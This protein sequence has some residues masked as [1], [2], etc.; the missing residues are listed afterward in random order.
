MRNYVTEYKNP[1]S[2]A[3]GITA[4]CTRTKKKKKKKKKEEASEDEEKMILPFRK[5]LFFIFYCDIV[6][7]GHNLGS[8]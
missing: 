4:Q 3:I 6:F 1:N 8:H 5:R 7:F 2:T